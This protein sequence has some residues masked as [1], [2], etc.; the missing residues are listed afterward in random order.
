MV[1]A[2]FLHLAIAEKHINPVPMKVI[3]DVLRR[4]LVG[5]LLGVVLGVAI[6]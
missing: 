5:D 2:K 1:I 4:S 3:A 6:R